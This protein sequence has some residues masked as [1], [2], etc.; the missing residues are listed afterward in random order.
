MPKYDKGKVARTKS[1]ALFQNDDPRLV[2]LADK[3]GHNFTITGDAT[4]HP[5]HGSGGKNFDIR[6]WD[7]RMQAFLKTDE[8][9]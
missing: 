7:G 5:G 8:G 9:K 3:Y 6:S 4:A 1:G 2:A